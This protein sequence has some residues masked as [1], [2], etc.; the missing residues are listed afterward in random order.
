MGPMI[1]V[2]TFLVIYALIFYL[3]PVPGP[4]DARRGGLLL[5]CVVLPDVVVSNWLGDPAAFAIGERLQVLAIAVGMFIPIGLAG[6]LLLGLL[7]AERG[8]TRLERVFFSGCLG[9]GATSLYMLAIGLLGRL[10]DRSAIWAPAAIVLVAS[11][12]RWWLLKDPDPELLVDY[13]PVEEHSIHATR[14]D[15]RW[16]WFAAPF[17]AAIL[18]GGALPPID[19]DVREYHLQA[20]KE[21]YE[22]G[23]ITFL[24]HNAYASMPAGTE[25]LSLAAMQLV[26]DWQLGALVGKSLIALCAPWT[27]LGLLAAGRRW[28]GNRSGVMAALLFIS[29]PWIAQVS[30]SGMVEGVSAMFL[31]GAVY[32]VLLWRDG[33][34]DNR[35]SRVLLAGALS[36][37]AVAC[38]YPNLVFVAIPLA[39]YVAYLCLRSA[40]RSHNIPHGA[41]REASAE[42]LLSRLAPLAAFV[43]AAAVVCGPWFAKNWIFTGNPVYPLAATI[44]GGETRTP[45]LI[46]RWNKAHV[47][48]GFGPTKFVQSIINVSLESTLASVLIVPLAALALFGTGHRRLVLSLAAFAGC[49]LLVWW[50]F[51]HRI[52]RFYAPLF[53]VLAML[54][55]LAFT[56][57]R[58][59]GCRPVLDGFMLIGLFANLVFILAGGGGDNAYFAKA[60]Q[61]RADPTRVDPWKIYLNE[62]LKPGDALLTVGDAEVFDLTMPVYYN[63]VFDENLFDAW[64]KGRAPEEILR[65]LA[66]NGISHVYVNWDEIDRY[67]SRGN[68]G[69]SDYIQPSVLEE[70]VRQQVLDKPLPEMD[71]RTGRVYPVHRPPQ[72]AQ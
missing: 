53:P 51:T 48:D 52:D 9:L 47:P 33:A 58:W 43:L 4:G 11:A 15:Q 19:F 29:V 23:A 14:G 17:V 45:E 54:G 61:L 67:R 1:S 18:L 12:A 46:A 35:L 68:Y 55:S 42:P 72:G 71:T 10:H 70:L 31:W 22:Q 21:F 34:R 63:T 41:P 62:N 59:R 56:D 50:L 28:A 36:G 44:F 8:L 25:M 7:R 38:K 3:M 37:A 24:R 39:A 69:F 13:Q 26:G 66:D 60:D 40:G 64:F 32:A 6:W 57:P 27:A 5:R 16:L 30:S 65:T 49:Y 2:G 20:P